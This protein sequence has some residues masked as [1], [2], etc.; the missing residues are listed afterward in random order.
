MR[1]Q[2]GSLIL[3]CLAAM[4]IPSRAE[5]LPPSDDKSLV[6]NNDIVLVGDQLDAVT[7]KV[8]KVLKGT[9]QGDLVTLSELAQYKRAIQPT[10]HGK[11][12]GRLNS[13]GVVLFIN[14]RTRPCSLALCGVRRFSLQQRGNALYLYHSSGRRQLPHL[15]QDPAKRT[16]EQYLK[17]LKAIIEHERNAYNEEL[18]KRIEATDFS[19]QKHTTKLMAWAGRHTRWGYDEGIQEL[20]RLAADLQRPACVNAV[21]T[22]RRIRDPGAGPPLAAIVKRSLAGNLSLFDHVRAIGYIGGEGA[23][24]FLVRLVKYEDVVGRPS[25]VSCGAVH[26]LRWLAQ[27][28]EPGS[29]QFDAIEK[30]IL[31][32]STWPICVREALTALATEE[33]IRRIE[34]VASQVQGA[35]KGL[36]RDAKERAKKARAR[37]ASRRDKQGLLEALRTEDW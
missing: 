3:F 23:V 7:V 5:L 31:G 18:R 13:H 32:L 24:P 26:G 19:S 25:G 4:S 36:H 15:R 27:Q 12:I 10:S 16:K 2:V 11:V 1:I 30:A 17:Q 28:Y 21:W 33:A 8:R 34:S 37:W 14:G 35:D 29:E 22:L 6:I 20:L 9:W